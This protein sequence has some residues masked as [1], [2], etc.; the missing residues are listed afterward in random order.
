MSLFAPATVE[1]SCFPQYIKKG[2]IL[3]YNVDDYEGY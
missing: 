2:L 1:Q 3:N